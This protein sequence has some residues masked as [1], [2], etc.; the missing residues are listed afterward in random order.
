MK[1]RLGDRQ[2]SILNAIMENKRVNINETN[3]YARLLHAKAKRNERMFLEDSKESKKLPLPPE[4]IV[5]DTSNDVVDIVMGAMNEDEVADLGG[6]IVDKLSSMAESAL[7]TAFEENS[8][9]YSGMDD[10]RDFDEDAIEEAELMFVD[11]V[12][13]AA[14]VYFESIANL[15]AVMVDNTSQDVEEEAPSRKP[16]GR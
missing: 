11:S 16:S 12:V 8:P 2:A 9:N 3:E 15:A 5:D 7:K 14:Y 10:L 6:G 4:V 1:P 13:S